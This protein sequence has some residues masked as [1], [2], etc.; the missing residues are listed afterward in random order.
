MEKEC[1]IEELIFQIKGVEG[2]NLLRPPKNT[3]FI[4]RSSGVFKDL[5]QHVFG[6]ANFN[7]W[8]LMKNNKFLLI[9]NCKTFFC[10]PF[11]SKKLFILYYTAF[12]KICYSCPL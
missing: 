8:Y 4:A 9:F 10:L 6:V 2:L 12:T 5:L 11:F 3:I 7:K 1:A